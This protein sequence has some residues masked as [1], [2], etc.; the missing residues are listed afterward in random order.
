[1]RK[2]YFLLVAFILLA[3][4]TNAQNT[5]TLTSAAGTDAQAVCVNTP[6]TTITYATTGATG[7]I[8]ADLPTGVTG[9]WAANVVTI[10]G[11]PTTT[12]GS[13][14]NYT[15]TLTGGDNTGSA[16]GIITV[17]P[18]PNAVAT[19]ASQT[20]C[21]GFAITTIVN[22]GAVGGTV[23]NWTRDNTISVTGI[24]ASGAGNISGTLT[25]TTFAPITVTFTITP[26]ASGCPG[27]STTATVLVNPTPNAIATPASQTICSGSAITTI[28]NSSS[29]GGTTYTWTRNNTATVIGIAASGSGNISGS[30]TNTSFAPIMVT[31]TIT[32]TANGCPGSSTTATVLVNPTPTVNA[33]ASQ[34]KCNGAASN[35]VVFSGNVTGTV[36]NW[37][38][39]DPSIGLAAGGTG[40]I[41]P[42][43]VTNVTIDPVTATITVTPSFTNG[44][45]TCTGASTSFTITLNPTATVDVVPNQVVCSNTLTTAINFSSPSAGFPASTIVYNW[46]NTAPAIGLPGSGT[47]NIPAFTATNNTTSPLVANITVTPTYTYNSVSCTGAASTFSITVNPRSTANAIANQSLCNGNATAAVNFSSTYTGGT[48]VYNWVNN[49]PSIGLAASGA[50]NI[51]SFTATNVTTAPVTATIVVTPTYTNNGVSC[52]GTASMFAITVNPTASVDPVADETL[53]ANQ[54][55]APIVFTSP[56]SGTVYNW[57]NNNAAIGL[58]ASGIG[59]IPSFTTNNNLTNATAATITVRPTTANGCIGTAINFTITVNPIATINAVANQV[60]CSGASTAAINFSSPTTGGTIV[61]N[62]VNN[63]PS[64]GIA[65]SGTGNIPTFV[66]SN[67]TT[68]PVI[69]TITVTP[70]FTNGGVSCVGTFRTFTITVNPTATVNLVSNETTCNGDATAAI[71]F[72]S[73]NSGNG[74]SNIVFNWVNNTTSIGLAASGTGNIAS[75]VTI[76]TG[77]TPAVATITVTPTY[78]NGG[79]SCTGTPLSFTINVLPTAI[80]NTV[81]DQT[82]CNNASTAA[83]TFSSPNSGGILT[84]N[85]FN[86]NTSIGLAA[87]GSGN[88]ASFTATNTTTAPVTANITVTPIFTNSAET[89]S[90]TGTS[91]TFTITVN[92]TATVNPVANQTLCGN[93]ITAPIVFSGPVAGTTYTWVNNNPSIGLAASGSGNIPSFTTANNLTN[94]ITATITV[95]PTTTNGCTGTPISFTITVNPI[96]TVNAVANQVL[97]NGAST[98]AI[99][100]SSPATGGTVTFNWVNDTPS[101]GIAASGSGNIPSFTA[102]NIGLTPVTATIT[103]TPT[104]TNNAVSCIGTAISFTITVNPTATVNAVANQVLCNAANTTAITFSSPNS[105]GGGSNIVYNWVNNTP[106]IGLAAS[107][108][109]NIPSFTASNTGTAPVTATIT[110]TPT[111]VNGG[112]SCVGT[113]RTFTITVNP[114]G[115]VNQVAN[116]VYCNGASTGITVLNSSVSGT[117]FSWT[118]SNIAIG[119]AASGAGNVPSFTATNAGL[120]P[121]TATITVTPTYTNGGV[122]CAGTPI[123]YTITVNPT[124][125]VNAVVNQT[126]CANQSTT[127]ITFTSPNSGNG[128]SNVVFNWVNNTPSIGLAASGN[129]N[130]ASFIATNVTTAPITATITVTPT[131]TNAGVSCAGTSITFTITVN[132]SATVNPVANQSLCNNSATTAVNFSSTYT[133][134]TIVYNWTNTAPSIGLA[135]SGTGNIASFTATNATNA[136]VTAT[137]TV[138]PTFTNGGVS[139]A[140]TSS[141]FTITV[142]PTAT[143][144]AVAN[145]TLCGN[146]TTAPIV[147]SSAVSGVTYTWVNNNTAIGLAAS[148]TGNIPSFVT[149]NNLTNAT[150]ATITVTPSTGNGCTGTPITFTITV[151][152]IATVNTVAN[153]V[154]CNG[155]STAAIVFSSPATG[156]TIVYNWT[157]NAPSIGIAASGTG[158]IPTFIATNNTTTPVVASITVTPTFTNN[159]VSCVGTSLTFT[160][161]VNPTATVNAVTNQVLCNGSSTTAITFT[162]PNSGNG[163]SNVVFNWANNNTGIGLAASGAGN[164]PSFTAINNSNVPVA[165]TITVAPTYTNAGVSCVGT[166]ITFTIT[167]NPTATV[168]AIANQSLCANN[169]TAAVNFSSVYT[170]GSIVYN[171]VNNSP[172]IGLAASGAGNIASFIATNATSAPVTATITVTPTFTNAG[173]SCVGTSSTFTITVNPTATVNPV[174]NQTLCAN[175]ATVPIVFSSPVSGTTYTWVNNNPSIGLAASGSGNIPSFVTSNTLTNATTATITVTPSIVSGCTGAPITFTITVNP[176]ATVNVIANQVLCN[177]SS[178]AAI[179]FSSPA[180]GGTI[181]Y[182]WTNNAASIGIAASGTGNIPTFIATNNTTTPVVATITVTPTF[183]NNSVS[184]VGLATTFTITV[185]PTATVNA[186]ASQVLCNASSTSAIAFVSPNGGNGGSNVVFNWVNNTPSIGLAANG[187]GN[188]GSFVATNATTAPITA[189]IIVTPTYTNAGVSC[190]GTAITFTFTVNPTATVNAVANQSL[191]NNTPTAAVNFSSVYTG[192]SVVYN[193]VNNTPSI[194]LAA[195]GSGNIASFVASNATNTPVT[196][197]IT[198]TPT[199][200]NAGVS[201]VGTSSTFT[202]TVNPT[203]NVNAI[204]NQILCANTTTSPIVFSS[205]VSG[206]TYSWVNNNPSI[207]LGASGTGNIPSFVTANNL[208]NAITATITVTPTSPNGC[209]GLP[210]TFTITVNPVATVNAVANQVL[211]NGSSTAAIAFSS[212]ATGGSVI[213]TWSNNAPSI[214]LA[215]AGAGNIPTFIATNVGLTPVIATIIVTPTFINGGV[216]CV[217]TVSTFTITVNPTATVNAVANQVLCNASSSTAIIF[218]SPNSGNGGSNVVFNWVNNTPSIGLAASGAGNIASFIATNTTTAPVVATITVTPTYTNG[219]VSCVGTASTFNIT[220]NPTATVNAVANQSLCNNVATAAVNF[221]ST[222]TGGSIVYNWV[223]NTPSIGLAATGAG[224]IASFIATNAT[225]APVTA[226]ITVTPTFTSGG[227]SCVGTSST[228]T[229]TVNPTAVVNA[230]ANQSLCANTTTT[231]IV[232]SSPVSGTTY[233]WVNNNTAIGLVASGVGNIPSFVTTNNLNSINA[234]I[235]ATPNS[236]FGCTGLPITFVITVNPIATVNVVPNQIRCNG[237]LTDSIK[238]TSPNGNNGGGNIVYNW[239]NTA[240][241]IGL[242]A[243]GSG[244]ILPFTATN[245]GAVPVNAIITV[246]PSFV[247]GTSNCVGIPITFSITVNPT[248]VVNAIANQTVC[249]GQPTAPVTL[250]GPVINTIYNWVNSNPAIGLAASGS[251]N[252]GSF[253]AQNPTTNTIT[254]TITV[255]PNTS[256]GCVGSSRSF[257]IIVPGLSIAATSIATPALVL[258]DTNTVTTLRVVG[259]ALGTGAVWRWYKDSCGGTSFATGPVLNNIIVG[260]TTTFYVRAEG[261][262]NTTACAS[263]R[264]Q[265]AKLV[266]HVRQHWSDVLFFDNSSNNF[267]KWQWYKNGAALSGATQQYYSESGGLNGTYYV[268]ATDKNGVELLTCPLVIAAGG[269]QSLELKIS[270]NPVSRGQAYRLISSLTP[271]ELQGAAI[272]VRDIIGTQVTQSNTSTPITTLQA[273]MASGMYVV[274]LVLRNGQK[275]SVTMVVR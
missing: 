222:Y 210:I 167:V 156:G 21:S 23:Y 114:I 199:F 110:V 121:I 61:Y 193:W 66:A 242:A 218:T 227:V 120:S 147:F 181:V 28:V 13:P 83:I 6:I 125:T 54:I 71:N 51:A 269:F 7:A 44:G 166:A 238:F 239:V 253:I 34:V 194:G 158:N 157:N 176:I 38:N 53:C 75:F 141:T 105:G 113:A 174:A 258:C 109:G 89:L 67:I 213:F 163:G 200:T 214:G 257:D 184:C 41:A 24:A 205:G 43:T 229:I 224:N 37:T 268:V 138:T 232:F 185:N 96:A 164:I 26:T 173:V 175:T 170:G 244:N 233:T 203:G 124:A 74:G 31:F 111:F 178:T 84:Y 116:Q 85:W 94:A 273:P 129:G 99:I 12:V 126:L 212:P 77:L 55:T 92:P 140:G 49:D 80:V 250:T 91:K 256:F 42:F 50:G 14:F 47:G 150:T 97:C 182:N 11:S 127:A 95:T 148:G 223:N 149:V 32:P 228:F 186:V 123:S 180:T 153:Q 204:S 270:P 78:T 65:A 87:S 245:A 271:A 169:A 30:L 274:T 72:S 246:T 20:S 70:T 134:G 40:N 264:V 261:T 144:N 202:I 230:V 171:W 172:S 248:A 82:L 18:T 56:V 251:G 151:N 112:V 234:T 207:G 33:V 162:S 81:A 260:N 59:N 177:G 217:G 104:F 226:T 48:I 135:A 211:C 25:N 64:I 183:T 22:S 4:T 252:I 86:D 247:N 206:T 165:A 197:T 136:S 115:T 19:P 73:P 52:V 117:T 254:G 196:A 267:V 198:I 259:G 93:T 100:F 29:A 195:S 57:V 45:T 39:S 145:Q 103:V 3:T 221:S 249:A 189:T 201:C 15:V 102:T 119:L 272:T 209:A 131:Y 2:L 46:V 9:N 35:A 262:C 161:T 90:C 17:N 27:P 118:N 62:W 241:S 219:G 179:V 69:A 187:V 225:N 215:A 36:Y 1:M 10:S 154:L 188:I 155:S 235:T 137:I 130:I 263:V 240:P 58:A 76:N 266:T 5:I 152:P 128:G 168:N 139:C 146:T 132:P 98:G 231:P 133:G 8:F 63:A 216:S 220:V 208:T 192:G 88:I 122:S 142:Y 159:G 191:C 236:P 68:A 190:V 243:T 143:V 160:I 237:T 79:V 255:T 101:I 107:G 265:V 16:T 275:Y 60:L 106:S 108:A